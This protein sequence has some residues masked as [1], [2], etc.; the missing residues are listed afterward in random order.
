MGKV[1]NYEEI[2]KNEHLKYSESFVV[3]F[4]K[5]EGEFWSQKEEMYFT[6]TK[7][8]HKDVLKRWTK[9]NLGKE[10]KYISISYQ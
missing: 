2:K 1:L 4:W 5:K 9:D 8:E 7:A 10:V 6:K 3:K